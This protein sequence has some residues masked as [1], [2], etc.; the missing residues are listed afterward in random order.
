M[1]AHS[2]LLTR[3]SFVAAGACAAAALACGSASSLV[4]CASET[5]QESAPE[6]EPYVCPYN[7]EGLVRDGDK[8]AYYEGDQLR[9]R[10]GI[11]VSEHQGFIDWAAVAQ[12]GVQFAFVRVGNR[13]A[14]E[15]VLGVDEY[16]EYNAANVTAAGIEASAYFFSQSINEDEAREEAAFAI[17]QL[18]AAEANGAHFTALAYD[19]EP[20]EIEGARAND[21]SRDQFTANALAFC[22][23]VAKAGYQPLLYGNQKD[24]LLLTPEARAAYPV[25]LAEYDV[26]NPTAQMDFVLW[27]YTNAGTVS[28]IDTPVDLNLWLEAK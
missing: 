5:Q 9:S 10:W 7:W 4:G 23:E 11:D 8:L 14:T 18:R 17:E 16:F 20:V 12:A 21:L 15:G 13:G 25:W 1:T 22:E 28:G 6:P 19:H 26:P 27:Q 24:L 2:P 3:R